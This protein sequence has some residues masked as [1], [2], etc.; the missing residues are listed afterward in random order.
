[1]KRL[2]SLSLAATAALWASTALAADIA[3][4]VPMAPAM[5][6]PVQATA[7][8]WTGFYVGVNGGYS[9]GDAVR[10][11]PNF[12]LDGASLG[13]QAGV[14][15]QFGQI[16]LGAETDIQYSWLSDS[17]GGDD[18]DLNYFGTLRARAGYAFDRVLPYVTGG[19]AYGEGEFDGAGNDD[20]LH[21]GYTVGAGV[22][23]AFTDQISIKGEYLYTD[24]GEED[25]AGT[26][27]DMDFH[28]VRLGLNYRF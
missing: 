18:F 8:D 14:N 13:G 25:Y 22:E 16:V 10:V 17:A 20:N 26:D 4:P 11:G 24:L 1:M 15:Y 7:F 5:P 27:I 3:E 2:V 9:F 28:T 12:E 6:M 19:L 23:Y 21:L